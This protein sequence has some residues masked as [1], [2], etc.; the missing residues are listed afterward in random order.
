MA[1][2]GQADTEYEVRDGLR[3]YCPRVRCS[4]GFADGLYFEM[5]DVRIM[6]IIVGAYV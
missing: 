2:Y 5:Y 6:N 3:G 4:E 1:A